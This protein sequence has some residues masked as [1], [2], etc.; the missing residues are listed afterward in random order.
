MADRGTRGN[1]TGARVTA[2]ICPLRERGR[3]PERAP[4]EEL[5]GIQPVAKRAISER[6][7]AQ[8]SKAGSG[9]KI[10]RESVAEILVDSYVS[11]RTAEQTAKKYGITDRTLRKYRR[12]LRD[13]PVLADL[14]RSKRAKVSEGWAEEVPGAMRASVEFLRKAAEEGDPRDPLMVHSVAGAM[15][16]LSEVSATWKILDARL[17]RTNRPDDA[18]VG[19]L[20]GRGAEVAAIEAEGETVR[21]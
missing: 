21:H 15:K 13:D 19:A 8:R 12:R 20:P 5:N 17:A 16:L 4:R 1:R 9:I 7:R 10:D 3:T 18:P 6:E 11:G 2:T 14:F